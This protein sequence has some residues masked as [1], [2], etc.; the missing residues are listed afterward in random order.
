M[1]DITIP[2]VLII[3]EAANPEWAS[4]PL[5]GWSL[6][7]AI[8]RINGAHIVTQVRNRDA[9]LRAGLVEGRDFTAINSERVVRPLWRLSNFLRGDDRK[10]WTTGT[11]ISAFG[12]YYF[13]HLVWRRFRRAIRSRSIDIVHRITPL[14]PTT[15]ST[16]ASRCRRNGVRFV[17]GPLNGGV[18]WPKEFDRARRAER[19]WLTYVRSAYRLL[20]G[21]MST[22][23][24]SD[25]ILT[26]S[27]Y[28]E[29]RIP[30]RYSGKCTYLPENAID[31]SRFTYQ[32]G[33]PDNGVLR[34]CFIGRLVPYKG[35][36]MAISASVPF[37]R[38]GTMQLDVIGNGPMMPE[39]KRIIGENG[40]EGSVSMHGWVPH[41]QVQSLISKCHVLLFPSIREFGGG[42]VL[43][44]MAMGIVPIVVD[45]AG[46]G[47][48]VDSEVGIKVPLGSRTKII[49]NIRTV[50]D[51]IQKNTYD[52]S[53]LAVNGM[54]RIE[55][56]YTWDAKARFIHE[57]Y[58]KVL[59]K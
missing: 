11:A 49:E 24:N 59:Q 28:T 50:I 54:R 56:S 13:E 16:I 35:A 38:N 18:P 19:E 2:R 4:V 52:L 9:F 32:P 57:L 31:P 44:A 33:R 5:V 1:S 22:L 34:A 27:R 7:T 39:L 26:G 42:V 14:S 20:P 8:R 17:I 55:R 12:Y 40:L 30:K 58:E 15:P 29:S 23:R 21:Y 53:A 6:A 51:K 48:L 37:L 36:D 41:H 47:E 45:Y 3:A 46:P 25:M 10:G 43:E